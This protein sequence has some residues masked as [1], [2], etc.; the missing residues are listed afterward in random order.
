MRAGKL[1]L[2]P[3]LL[4]DSLSHEKFLPSLIFSTISSLNGLIAESEK[5]AR[6]YLRAFVSHDQ[7]VK[8]PICLLNEHTQK[9]DIAALLDPLLRGETWGLISDAGL[10]CIADPGADLV[11]L[12]HGQNIA[13]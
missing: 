7:M 6:R 11:R 9:E 8:T 2:L 10:P 4:D 5:S 3:N 1:I 12:A 13:I